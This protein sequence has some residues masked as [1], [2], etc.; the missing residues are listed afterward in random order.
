MDGTFTDVDAD[1]WYTTTCDI[2]WEMAPDFDAI[3]LE[4]EGQT[5][6][7]VTIDCSSQESMDMLTGGEEIYVDFDLH[8]GFGSFESSSASTATNYS[9]RQDDMVT[10]T[11]IYENGK[12]DAIDFAATTVASLLAA[13]AAYV[14]SMI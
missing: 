12:E 5:F 1:G 4:Y 8:V 13:S 9:E 2:F 11:I 7:G 3:C 6:D 10:L 14:A